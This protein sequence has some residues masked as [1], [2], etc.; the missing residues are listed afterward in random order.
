METLNLDEE[1]AIFP[2]D[3]DCFAAIGAALC[4][5]DYDS[6]PFD[7]ALKLLEESRDTTTSVNTMPPSCSRTRRST[8]PSVQRHNATHPPVVDIATYT[9]DAYLGIDAGST[10]TK[11]ALIAP[12]GGLLYTYYHSNQ[13]NPVAVVQGAAVQDL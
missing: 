6:I 9:G 12:D 13:G 11:L 1:H 5:S 2:E 4:A 8:R 10:T 3:G 7:K